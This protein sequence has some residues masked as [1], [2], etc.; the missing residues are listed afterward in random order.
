MDTITRDINLHYTEELLGKNVI[1]FIQKKSAYQSMGAHTQ[2]NR[3][4]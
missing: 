4:Y 3:P 2:S 1:N